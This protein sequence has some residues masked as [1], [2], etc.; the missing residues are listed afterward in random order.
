MNILFVCKYNRFRSQVAE[1]FFNQINTNKSLKATS[2]GIF[3]GFSVDPVVFTV[4]D[5]YGVKIN[6]QP[7]AISVE[8]IRNQDLI[9]I[10]ADDVP[11]SLFTENIKFKRKTIVWEIPDVEED[12]EEGIKQTFESI[13]T[14]VSEF[15]KSNK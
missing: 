13:K 14:K 2:A 4:A 6:G 10:V 9:V 7:K 8:L 15:L 5:E 12:N 11:I 3:K 1:A